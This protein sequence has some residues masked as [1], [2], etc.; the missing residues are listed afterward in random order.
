MAPCRVLRNSAK[1][2]RPLRKPRTLASF[3][4]YVDR[5]EFNR[6][7]LTGVPFPGWGMEVQTH[8]ALSITIRRA[9]PLTYR[10]PT[11]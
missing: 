9:G 7:G 11:V 5:S 2:A 6:R 3:G 1:P 4:C 10:H 8:Q